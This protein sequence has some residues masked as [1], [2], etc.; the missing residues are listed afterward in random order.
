MYDICVIY[1]MCIV[2]VIYHIIAVVLIV[3]AIDDIN[4][5][6]GNYVGFV[7]NMDDGI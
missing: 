7:D 2:L 1:D 6:A 4:R 3:Y 5:Y